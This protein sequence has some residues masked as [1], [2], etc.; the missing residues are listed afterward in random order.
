MK[1]SDSILTYG[2]LGVI[3]IKAK[4]M[5]RISK[6]SQRN[7][8]IKR[9]NSQK[10]LCNNFKNPIPRRKLLTAQSKV[11]MFT[12]HNP[13]RKSVTASKLVR[14]K[15]IFDLESTDNP[16]K[17]RKRN[18]LHKYVDRIKKQHPKMQFE[19]PENPNYDMFDWI[20]QNYK[21]SERMISINNSINL[22]RQSELKSRIK[23]TQKAMK[24]VDDYYDKIPEGIS[25]QEYKQEFCRIK[26]EMLEK[27]KRNK[28]SKAMALKTVRNYSRS[29]LLSPRTTSKSPI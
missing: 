28:L 19:V 6:T 24:K 20:S 14:T 17:Y 8:S 21:L 11:R 1:K 22:K 7:R 10:E 9:M 5:S 29:N 23:K 13:S 15:N 4:S 2:N 12:S 25:L 3:Y 27:A 26:R 18:D 16:L